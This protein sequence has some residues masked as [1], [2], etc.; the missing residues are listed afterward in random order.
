[1]ASL[2]GENPM[3]GDGVGGDSEQSYR[4]S[5]SLLMEHWAIGFEIT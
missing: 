3:N 1:M 2:S 4:G 5:R